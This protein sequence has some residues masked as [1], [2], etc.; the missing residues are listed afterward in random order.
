MPAAARSAASRPPVASAF[1][2]VSPSIAPRHAFVAGRPVRI[3]F[4]IGASAPLALRIE[5]VRDATGKPVRRFAL[6][7]VAPGA[8]QHLDWDGVIG[9]EGAPDGTYHVRAISPGGT[10]RRVGLPF[11]LHSHAYPI[12]G[13]HADRGPIGAFGVPRDGGRTHEGFDVNAPCATPIVA[14]RGGRVVRAIYD[15][16]LYGNLLV[17]HGDH[18]HRDY[19]YAHM[20]RPSR[21]RA[22][23][24]VLTGQR[25]G[26]IGDTGNARTIGCHLHFEIHVNGTPI[27]PAPQLHAWDAWS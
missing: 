13:P 17:I 1:T 3:S 21:L 18:T 24:R 15:P 25:I 26:S 7:A 9:G 8:E 6:P 27:D 22:G 14:A 5:I 23:D 4:A 20:K 16:V 2:I 10:K 11:T 12:R 19:W